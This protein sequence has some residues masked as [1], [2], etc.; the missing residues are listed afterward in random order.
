MEQAFLLGRTRDIYQGTRDCVN[1]SKGGGGVFLGF[2]R[3]KGYM[4]GAG[5]TK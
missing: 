3:K 2:G 5:G 4:S 1:G